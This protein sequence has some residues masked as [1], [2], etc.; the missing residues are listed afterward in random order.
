[1]KNSL[2]K[3]PIS[4]IIDREIRRYQNG[5]IYVCLW[6]IEACFFLWTIP[7]VGHWLWPQ[8]LDLMKEKD[9]KEWHIFFLISVVYN[10]LC[11]FL[12]NGFFW[13]LYTLDHPLI[14][15]FKV[16][17]GKWPWQENKAEWQNI[18]SKTIRVI[19]FNNFVLIPL[20]SYLT[21]LKSNF[22][23]IHS[24]RIEELPDWGT[25]AW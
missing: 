1:M 21:L 20:A 19:A 9:L 8:V 18:L 2:S 14:E 15:Q 10:N 4:L 25:L 11:F 12:L 23:V 13:L 22:T 7:Q 5:G 24:F 16:Y 6:L 3:V 17:P